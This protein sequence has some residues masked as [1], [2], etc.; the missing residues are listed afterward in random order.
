MD[1][2]HPLALTQQD[3]CEGLLVIG[4]YG[5]LD[6]GTAPKLRAALQA[7][8][9]RDGARV[10]LD[11]SELSMIDST[12]LGLLVTARKQ[13]RRRGGDLVLVVPLTGSLWPKLEITGLDRLFSLSQ[14]RAEALQRPV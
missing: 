12:G 1:S 2:P 7:A 13:L 8:D 6:M 5:E 9:G 3:L 4:L 11:L 10:V 14:S